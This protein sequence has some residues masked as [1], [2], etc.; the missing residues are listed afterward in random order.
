VSSRTAKADDIDRL[1]DYGIHPAS[2]TV[3]LE[4]PI[5][6]E[7]GEHGVG[8]SMAQRA[9]KN[10]RLLDAASADPITLIINTDGGYITH[11][12]AIYDAIRMCRSEVRGLVI[13]NAQSMGCVILQA[14]D[15]RSATTHS[16]IMYHAGTM[17]GAPGAALRE[18]IRAVAYEVAL[19][20]R[21]DA[22]MLARV[23]EK[24]PKLTVAKFRALLDHGL[25]LSSAEAIEWGLLDHIE[26]AAE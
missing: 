25:Y 24:K 9:I 17:D 26:G 7:G 21:I 8:Y 13:G 23:R 11:G 2:R 1:H 14:C 18:G 22:L 3:F 10:L 4:T 5:D 12:V 6:D 16:T 19:G 15:V 20:D